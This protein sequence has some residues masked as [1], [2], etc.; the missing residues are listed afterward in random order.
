M[1]IKDAQLLH[2]PCCHFILPLLQYIILEHEDS[3]EPWTP[4]TAKHY[5]TEAEGGIVSLTTRIW[6]RIKKD[7]NEE[8]VLPTV[9]IL[10]ED[11]ARFSEPIKSGKRF[12]VLWLQGPE[13][14]AMPADTRP[15]Q[16][17]EAA[18]VDLIIPLA[19]RLS[20]RRVWP[21]YKGMGI[22]QEMLEGVREQ[23]ELERERKLDERERKLDERERKL[24]ERER[25]LDERERKL[26]GRISY[27]KS[28]A[29]KRG[30]SMREKKED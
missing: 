20:K 17:Q 18:I 11:S 8:E 2:E 27:R 29:T 22:T 7:R 26:N 9:D 4:E 24:D 10:R 6:R 13:N 28:L 30:S 14:P 3:N 1:A 19:E 25:K 16:G 21:D 5:K 15:S 23:D 12:S